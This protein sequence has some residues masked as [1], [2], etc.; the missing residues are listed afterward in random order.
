MLFDLL[1]KK[2]AMPEPGAALPGRPDPIP[3]AETHFVNRPA[4]EGAVSRGARAGHVRHG[5]LLG[6][7]ADVL[8]AARRLG[9]RRRLRRGRARPNPNY[10]EVCSG[11]TG[12]NEVVLV[13]YDPK[14]Q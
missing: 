7:R 2:S 4:A 14:R 13:V 3:T 8:E 6:R 12:H 10:R 9:D 1:K 11:R 5:L